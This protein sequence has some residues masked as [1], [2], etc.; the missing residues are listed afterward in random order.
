MADC[1]TAFALTASPYDDAVEAL[2]TPQ[3]Y[4]S[5]AVLLNDLSGD[6]KRMCMYQISESLD[7]GLKDICCALTQN[8]VIGKWPRLWLGTHVYLLAIIQCII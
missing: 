7:D 4:L 3:R 2:A 8:F 6:Q 5:A 1:G